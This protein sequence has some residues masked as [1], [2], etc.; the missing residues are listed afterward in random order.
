MTE[1]TLSKVGSFCS[2]LS[3]VA[4]FL[5][6]PLELNDLAIVFWWVITIF[7]LIAAASVYFTRPS[8]FHRLIFVVIFVA[9][10]PPFVTSWSERTERDTTFTLVPDKPELNSQ[11][12]LQDTNRELQ[13]EAYLSLHFRK[14][15]AHLV[16][17]CAAL[18]GCTVAANRQYRLFR[19]D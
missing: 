10:I 17:M 12:D 2:I 8:D 13:H 4:V 3:A 1:P 19:I 6:Q 9:Q 5:L 16:G 7:T 11:L 14:A 18:F 15:I